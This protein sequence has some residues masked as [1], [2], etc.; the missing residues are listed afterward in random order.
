[1]GVHTRVW[2]DTLTNLNR[3]L[4]R[5]S[6][7]GFVMRIVLQMSAEDSANLVDTPAASKLGPHRALFY[8]EDE[9]LLEKFRPYAVPSAAWLAWAAAQWRKRPTQHQGE[10][11]PI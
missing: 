8:N 11:D 10:N 7:R 3:N 6:L 4:D 9:G 1:M 5:R 2:C